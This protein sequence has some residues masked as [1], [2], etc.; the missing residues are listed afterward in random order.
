M[1]LDEG[2]SCAACDGL[3]GSLF[4]DSEGRLLGQYDWDL[5]LAERPGGGWFG[6]AHDHLV[7]MTP[8]AEVQWRH[9]LPGGGSFPAVD[10]KGCA[11]LISQEELLVFTPR[12]DCIVRHHLGRGCGDPALVGPGRLAVIRDTHLLLITGD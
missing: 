3:G 2:D 10:S 5:K 1:V 8:N 6:V 9:E 7:A 11:H 12:G 4:F